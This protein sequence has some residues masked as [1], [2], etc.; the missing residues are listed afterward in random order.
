[1]QIFQKKVND[2]GWTLDIKDLEDSCFKDNVENFTSYGRDM[3]LLLSKVKIC[4]SRRVFTEIN[5]KKLHITSHDIN[6]GI[7]MFIKHKKKK[8][9]PINFQTMYT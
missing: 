8:E 3:E 6:N 4:H 7:T 9:T 2:I 5:G 1:M